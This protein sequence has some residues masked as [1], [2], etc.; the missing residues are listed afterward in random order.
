MKLNIK[1]II[2]AL[3]TINIIQ[4]FIG[5]I[6]WITL[7]IYGGS[8]NIYAYASVLLIL[9]S[10]II[11]IISL[12]NANRYRSDSM[13]ETIRNLE[14]LNTTLRSQR[15]D[16]LNH[17][18]VIYGL[19]ELKEYEE[20]K[21]YL[22]PVFKD[23][24]KVSKALKTAQPAVN[25]L[26][27][28]KMETAENKNI[29]LFLD[30]RS[31]LKNIPMEPWSLCIVLANII[32]NSIT[33]LADVDKQKKIYIE[34]EEDRRYYNFQIMNNGPQ[35]S[36]NHLADIFKQ[37]FTTKKEQGHGMGLYIVS[38]II[39]DVN[40]TINVLSNMKETMFYIQVPKGKD[41]KERPNKS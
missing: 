2:I 15:H 16:Y 3:I 25:A 11:T 41:N 23:I 38:K 28:V 14:D 31:D 22:E 36:E 30:I 4:F 34:I 18:Q 10:S 24:L 13:A 35:I 27:Q 19:M 29:D 37:G 26:L 8:I 33:C 39:E 6:I 32:D 40:G 9:L 20:A 21:N 7:G 17:F 5:I 12:Y 1:K